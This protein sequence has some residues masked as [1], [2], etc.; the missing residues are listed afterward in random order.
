[1]PV[2]FIAHGSPMNAIENNHFVE[3]WLH[4]NRHTPKPKAVVV[5]SAHWHVHGTRITVS[6]QPKVIHDFGGFPQRLYQQQYPA[7]GSPVLAQKIQNILSASGYSS[8]L[9][10]DWGLDHGSWTVLSQLY[11]HADIPVIQVSL[12]NQVNSLQQHYQLAVTLKSLREE[13]VLFI[14]SGGIVHNISKWMMNKPGDSIAWAQEF[15]QRIAAAVLDRDIEMLCNYQ[16]LPYASD[17]VPTL[18]HYLPLI[19]CMGLS[20]DLDA[21]TFSNFNACNLENSCSRSIRF[22]D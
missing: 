9:D 5:F 14:G 6:E 19:Y 10:N 4:L 16:K 7:K 21:I 17:A 1:M 18:E 22:S 8:Q 11:P 13:G 12:D 3:D 2:L 15:D 20:D